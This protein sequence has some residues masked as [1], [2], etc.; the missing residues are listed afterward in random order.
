MIFFIRLSCLVTPYNIVQKSLRRW[1]IFYTILYGVTKRL[2]RIKKFIISF[3]KLPNPKC[4]KNQKP[5]S[6][7]GFGFL[8]YIV[9]TLYMLNTYI[10]NLDDVEKTFSDSYLAADLA[11]SKTLLCTFLDIR[12]TYIIIQNISFHYK[13][14]CIIMLGFKLNKSSFFHDESSIQYW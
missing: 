6:Y 12:G 4:N 7:F 2:S 9:P 5:F 11:P 1:K 3:S 8:T 13:I 10:Q 14:L